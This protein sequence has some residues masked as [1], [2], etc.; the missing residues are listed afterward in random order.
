ME[1]KPLKILYLITKSNFGGAQ[2]YVYDL[3]MQAK[4]EGHDVVVGFG[5]HGTLEEKLRAAGVRTTSIESLGRDVH[6][7]LDLKSFFCLLE[8]FA[9]ETPDII[10]L[11]SSKMGGLGALA[12]RLWN[13]GQWVSR[14]LGKNGVPA[15]IVFT[16]HGW[17]FNEDRTDFSRFI[18]GI[19]HWC[20][21]ELSHNTIAVSRKTREQVSA[22]PFVWHKLKVVHNGVGQADVLPKAVAQTKITTGSIVAG[23]DLSGSIVIGTIAELHTNKG[24][25][26]AIEGMALLKKQISTPFVFFIIGDGEERASLDALIRKLGL[27]K[28][29]FL[30]GYHE[31][32][33]SLLSAF[34]IFLLPSIT[35]AFPYVILEAGKAGLPVVST[36]VGG[37][38]EVIDD[39]QSGIL[40][41]SKNPSEI[42]R[43]L[44]YLI[45]NPERRAS[46]GHTLA[47]RIRDRFNVET[48]ARETFAIYRK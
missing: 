1:E 47:D 24:F 2:R 27:E 6:P 46:L 42:A 43:A 22:L 8:L 38:P 44:K 31:N 13:T 18:I 28:D 25:S 5:G 14:F 16:G 15:R 26:Y 20:T 17:A 10:H 41:Q 21:I 33:D 48:M 12:A 4:R 3:A 7:L 9:D 29:V 34:D 11:N 35:E 23:R 39:M 36:A 45:E 19:L 30:L 40:I 37:I 32:A